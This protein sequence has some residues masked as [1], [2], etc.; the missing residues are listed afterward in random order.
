LYRW[1]CNKAENG[2]LDATVGWNFNKFLINEQ[3]QLVGYY[4]SGV[5]P[6]GPEIT[7]AIAK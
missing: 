3:G 5:K 1:L 4:P 6:M 7:E 2:A